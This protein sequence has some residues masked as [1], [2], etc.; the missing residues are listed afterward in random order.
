[1]RRP[2]FSDD[3]SRRARGG[4]QGRRGRASLLEGLEP[5]TLLA[6]ELVKDINPTT[7]TPV[8]PTAM[9]DLNGTLFFNAY[10]KLWRSDGTAAGTAKVT[11]NIW[12]PSQL[13]TMNGAMYFVSQGQLWKSDGTEA[14]SAVVSPAGMN[15]R[16]M[17]NVNGR[18]FFRGADGGGDEIWTSDGTQ[19]GTMRLKDIR[20]GGAGSNPRG[21]TAS[22]GRLF[23]RADDGASGEELWTSDGT[24][25]GTYRVK[26]IAP[27]AASS[28][29]SYLADVNG[30]LF[31]SASDGVS[32]WELW[33]SDGTDPGTSRVA[34]IRA[35]AAG[36]T[37]LMLRSVGGKV[38]FLANDNARGFEIW[39]SDGTAAGTNIVRDIV[40]G[41]SG[42]MI[43]NL[44]AAGSNLY[45]VADT[46]NG[47]ELW[48]SDGTSA[49]TVPV[50]QKPPGTSA[51]APTSMTPWGSR[52]V[53]GANGGNS[54]EPWITDGTL[55][56]TF[57]L[58][59]ISAGASNP[60]LFTPVGNR[61]FFSANDGSATGLYVS[62]GTTGGT[63][64]VSNLVSFFLNGSN[65]SNLTNVNGVGYFSANDSVNGQE[66]WR[67]DGT[68]AGTQLLADITPGAGGTSLSQFS[69]VGGTLFFMANSRLWKSDGTTGGTVLVS[70]QSFGSLNLTVVG[71]A[72][73]FMASSGGGTGLWK[74]DGTSGGT[75]FVKPFALSTISPE[76]L[77][78]VNGTLMFVANDGASGN[79]IWKSDGTAAGTVMVKDIIS[80]A[81]SS[82]PL[83]LTNVNGTLFFRAN[84]GINGYE[85]WKSDGTA[86]GT[87]MVKDIRPGAAAPVIDSLMAIN[88]TLFFTADDGVNGR[89]LWRSD[90]TS[91]G[92]VIVKDIMPGYR[93]SSPAAMTNAN[94]TLYF[95]ADDGVA[96]SELWKSDGTAAGTVLVKD[97]R[98]GTSGSAVVRMIAANGRVVFET[99]DNQ[100]WQSD[101]TAGGT[102]PVYQFPLDNE[103]VSLG[104]TV[105][106]AAWSSGGLELSKVDTAAAAPVQALGIPQPDPLPSVGREG[107]FISEGWTSTQSS[108]VGAGITIYDGMFAGDRNTGAYG[109]ASFRVAYSEFWAS[110]RDATVSDET[111]AR[112]LAR[113]VAS[114]GQIICLNLEI[115]PNDLRGV[116][117]GVVAL[118]VEKLGQIIDW[119]HDERPDVKVGYAGMFPHGAYLPP[120][121]GTPSYAAWQASNDRLAPL[122][123]KVDYFFPGI[124]AQEQSVNNW[125]AYY[126]GLVA[127]AS[128]FGK[129][130]VPFLYM[131]QEGSD[132]LLPPEFWRLQ[133]E[134]VRDSVGTA[135]VWGP[136]QEDAPWYLVARDFIQ[137]PAPL[138]PAAPTNLVAAADNANLLINL[139]WKDNAFNESGYRVERRASNEVN[140]T[141]VATLAAGSTAWSD[142]AA[143]SGADYVYRVVATN[144]AGDS[145][146]SNEATGR[147]IVAPATPTNVTASALSSRSIRVSWSE[148]SQD[149][150]GFVLE[151]SRQGGA[152]TEI[153]TLPATA[154]SYD[155]SALDPGT[156]YTYHVRAYNTTGSSPFSADASATTALS[157]NGLRARWRLDETSGV[158]ATDFTG[159]H[160]GT[161]TSGPAWSSGNLGGALSFDGVDDRVV[162]ADSADFRFTQAQDFTLSAWVNLSALPNRWSAV[163]AKAR[164][165]AAG[166]GIQIDPSNRWIAAG[167]TNLVG[168]TASVGWTHVSVVQNGV[169]NTRKLYVNGVEVASG[170]AQAANGTG[171][172]WFGGAETVSEFFA[173]KIDDVRLYGRALAS[174]ELAAF[175]NPKVVLQGT[176]GADLWTVRL[177]SAGDAYEFFN[178]A[179]ASG[180]P[181]FTRP[182]DATA[183]ISV[184]GSGGDDQ[185]MVD[186]ANGSPVPDY[187]FNF[188]GGTGNDT[189]AVKGAAPDAFSVAAGQIQRNA[190]I[191]SRTNVETLELGV[192]TFTLAAFLGPQT[193]RAKAGASLGITTSQIFAGLEIPGGVVTFAPNLGSASMATSLSITNGGKLNL[194]NG[195]LAIDYTGSSPL[196]TWGTSSYSGVAG[197]IISAYNGGAWNGPG[198]G[199]S[200]AGTPGTYTIGSAE[201]KDA[202]GLVSGS[203]R[204][205]NGRTV[206]D[207]SVL[208]RF[209]YAAD[210]NLD[211]VINADDYAWIDLYSALAGSNGF[212]HG[213]FNYD[214][215]INADDYAYID[216]LSLQPGPGLTI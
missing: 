97:I 79:E 23:F 19:A 149:V 200:S 57:E 40:P 42:A 12:D 169:A 103:M 189:F 99:N 90:G 199:T 113:Q 7:S 184:V 100:I 81:T 201:A 148:S 166:Y 119:M 89:E 82:G 59:N 102:F 31:F 205:W 206:D 212:V 77:T 91:G 25:G 163:I 92:T 115:W 32:G 71:S 26:D 83:L 93:G 109:F 33:K 121:V 186:F 158:V 1:M 105:L 194:A 53:F 175:A 143:T 110:G 211:G 80:G 2:R 48:K 111:N 64:L 172:L 123:Q 11:D 84:D 3:K 45:F 141:A 21:L 132:Q 120:A 124:Y 112:Q 18:L 49:G 44:T 55:A 139:T 58:K 135:V 156:T 6:A 15:P 106:I 191:I 65:I 50:I 142:N 162:V 214:G 179:T 98:A 14:G 29:P 37:P 146:A 164:G 183:S 43:D 153:A 151:R 133:L 60:S 155:D 192:G 160:D 108:S 177:D 144:A 173:G 9:V 101:G 216:V 117:E 4:R 46:G 122:A 62:D 137:S 127:E 202:L 125:L 94:G 134:V 51:F 39:S 178:N 5:R 35:G 22:N 47:R 87:M 88:G 116:S 30:T 8:S 193:L 126:K 38:M 190:S 56:G 104:S 36:S 130:V 157:D 85:L 131:Q 68:T 75:V 180:S 95:R 20:P 181:A 61:L 154:S 167:S 86:G 129:P 195:A 114:A 76:A 72:V 152:F 176:A 69:N 96:G 196:G 24:P 204:S 197:M 209:T 207:T 213:D 66:L 27:G 54:T 150:T 118:S 13:T 208:I 168:P 41:A 67:S 188:D 161:L 145:L 16:E 17:I 182:R 210:A 10:L 73:Y 198:I 52:L 70:T 140:F 215:A 185:L 28:G 171:S 107:S 128:R 74:S 136:W 159:G 138:I 187:G 63:N 78:N 203:T 170:A 147:I 165:S 174:T 34:D